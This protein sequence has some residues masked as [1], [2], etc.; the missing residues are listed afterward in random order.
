MSVLAT[1]TPLALT[2]TGDPVGAAADAPTLLFVPGWCGDRDVFDS[3]LAR[4]A[5]ARR[6]VSVDLPGHGGTPAIGDYGYAELLDALVATVEHAGLGRVVPVALSHAGWAALDL[7]ERLGADRV[8]GVVLLDWMVLGTPPGFAD[9]LAGLQSP[10]WTEVRAGL[11]EMWT[12]GIDNP[13]LHTYVASMGGYGQAHWHRA[14]REIAARFAARPV[15][16]QSLLALQ[17]CPTLHV[18]AQPGDD[19]VLRAQQE[20]ATTHPWFA[21]TRLEASSHFPMFEVPDEMATTI[22]SFVAKLA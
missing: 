1:T 5:P 13:T 7:R 4:S 21:V 16:L 8:P 10:G 17:P 15:P 11:F 12:S 14:G 3:L 9:A 20:F 19:A 6:A 18:Y 2:D 22:E